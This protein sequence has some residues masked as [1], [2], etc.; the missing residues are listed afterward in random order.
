LPGDETAQGLSFTTLYVPKSDGKT[1][2]FL[3]KRTTMKK[4]IA[5]RIIIPRIFIFYQSIEN[6]FFLK[7]G[8][9]HFR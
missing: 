4:I 8:S 7:L 1:K 9:M 3:K 6:I 2:A 5:T